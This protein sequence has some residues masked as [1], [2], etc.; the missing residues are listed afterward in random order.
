MYFIQNTRIEQNNITITEK[1]T[2]STQSP[3]KIKIHFLDILSEEQNLVQV[4]WQEIGPLLIHNLTGNRKES[5]AVG[6]GWRRSKI[7][8]R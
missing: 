2:S 4:V 1:N 3:I 6:A 5:F 8:S 7:F